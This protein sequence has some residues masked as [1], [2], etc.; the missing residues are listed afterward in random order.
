MTLLSETSRGRAI[1][2]FK[3]NVKQSKVSVVPRQPAKADSFLKGRA[4]YQSFASIKKEVA[5]GSAS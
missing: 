4:Q 3:T 5:V 2:T 1:A